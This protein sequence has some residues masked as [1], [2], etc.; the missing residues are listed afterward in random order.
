[1]KIKPLETCLDVNGGIIFGYHVNDPKRYGV[2]E[3]DSDFKA[4]SIEEKP[5]TQVKLC[6]SWF[7]FL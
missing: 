7:I 5:E 1:M 6:S 2:V 3:F 4:I